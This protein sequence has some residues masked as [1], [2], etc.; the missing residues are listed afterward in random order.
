MSLNEKTVELNLT[1]ELLN[2]LWKVTGVNHCAF[3]LTQQQEAQWGVDVAACGGN[4]GVFI[5]FKRAHVSGS[6]WQWPLNRTAGRDQ[7]AKLQQLEGRGCNVFYALPYFDTGTALVE[8]R[9]RLLLRTFWIRPS[10][11]NPSGGPTGHHDVQYDETSRRWTVHSSGPTD[12]PDP[13]GVDDVA[14]ALSAASFQGSAINHATFYTDIF[15]DGKGES[16]QSDPPGNQ[17]EGRIFLV[18]MGL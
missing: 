17:E 16:A 8:N 18:R 5:Q 13:F 1:T 3:G 14:Y 2:W 9:R 4:T 12:L 11:I 10:Q 6:I 7:H 15:L